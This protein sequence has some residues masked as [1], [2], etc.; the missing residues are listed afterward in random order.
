MLSAMINGCLNSPNVEIAGV[1]RYENLNNN[2]FLLA[3]KDFFSHK[4]EKTLINKYKLKDL[5]FKSSNSPEY[6][7][8]LANENVD[9][10]LVGT[11]R[12]KFSPE[13]FSIPKLGAI[14][15]H[16]SLLPKYRGP[17]PYLQTIK[18]RE[19]FS[20]FTFHLIDKNFDTGDILY[21][22]RVEILPFYTS[23][24]LRE[25]TVHEVK[26]SLPEFLKR[27]E[28]NEII[29]VKQDENFAS[30]YPNI[31]RYDMMLDFD[32]ETAA[33]IVARIKALHPWLP[34]YV[35]VGRNFYIPNPYKLSI[36]KSSK[37]PFGFD[38]KRKMIKARCKDGKVVV[39]R[40]VKKYRSYLN[41]IR[42]S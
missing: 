34:A 29:P 10:M 21:Q 11:W 40:D 22:K 33:E 15:I 7:R 32:K 38:V 24:E 37:V 25:A 31:T 42:Q 18:N 9:V 12:E 27:L 6:R 5:H 23:K 35:T 19:K 13:T 30:Y 8:F 28:H 39:M 36:E 20:G 2:R 3:L 14:N 17:N 16:P 26:K 4:V 41:V 1:L